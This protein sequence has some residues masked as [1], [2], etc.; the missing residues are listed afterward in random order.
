MYSV[1]S[2]THS[3]FFNW[4]HLTTPPF[5]I[6]L[7]SEWME[8]PPCSLKE[9]FTLTHQNYAQISLDNCAGYVGI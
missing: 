2:I 8:G 6:N 9:K 4:L 5:Q 3:W 1:T 7:V